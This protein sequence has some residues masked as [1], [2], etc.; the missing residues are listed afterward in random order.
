MKNQRR[1]NWET[2]GAQDEESRGRLE[3]NSTGASWDEVLRRENRE[4]QEKNIIKNLQGA[5][6]LLE[7]ETRDPFRR[8]LKQ[9]PKKQSRDWPQYHDLL[10]E[11]PCAGS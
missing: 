3:E 1:A 10:W 8:N 5:T 11:E 7:V 4:I 9:T 2:K 6:E